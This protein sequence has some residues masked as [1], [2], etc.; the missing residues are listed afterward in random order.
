MRQRRYPAAHEGRR[1][2]VESGICR[3]KNRSRLAGELIPKLVEYA[4]MNRA[5]FPFL[6]TSYRLEGKTD[7]TIGRGPGRAGSSNVHFRSRRR[8]GPQRDEAVVFSSSS[9]E[10]LA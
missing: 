8:A 7:V 5:S 4:A 3:F 10:L 6:I 9:Y 1:G 2:N